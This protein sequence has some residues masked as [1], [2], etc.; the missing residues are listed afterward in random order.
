MGRYCQ[1]FFGRSGNKVRRPFGYEYLE[2]VGGILMSTSSAVA[3]WGRGFCTALTDSEMAPS[4]G[5]NVCTSAVQSENEALVP[6]ALSALHLN[7]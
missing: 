5:A 6:T 1:S 4:S 2:A 7:M 3:G